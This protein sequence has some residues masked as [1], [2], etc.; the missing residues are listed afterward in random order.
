MILI[1]QNQFRFMLDFFVI[2]FILW[3]SKQLLTKKI[4]I[5]STE[6]IVFS[7]IS[8]IAGIVFFALIISFNKSVFSHKTPKGWYIPAIGFLVTFSICLPV[9]IYAYVQK[10]EHLIT[11]LEWVMWITIVVSTVSW[12]F[13][14]IISRR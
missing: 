2:I 1:Q 13:G 4:K 14:K 8:F 10:N 11:I 3:L 5:M 9:F 6:L 7:V 12:I